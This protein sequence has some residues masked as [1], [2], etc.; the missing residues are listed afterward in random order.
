MDT[1][2]LQPIPP[3]EM[4]E[5]IQNKRSE[6]NF[7]INNESE[8]PRSTGEISQEEQ[9]LSSA[10]CKAGGDLMRESRQDSSEENEEARDADPDIEARQ[11]FWNIM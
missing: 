8:F 2:E 1:E 11:D 10:V 3:S 6:N 7:N 4:H 9:Q 5:K